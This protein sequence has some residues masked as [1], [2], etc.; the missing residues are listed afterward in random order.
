MVAVAEE[1]E[2]VE[3]INQKYHTQNRCMVFNEVWKLWNGR[4]NYKCKVFSGP[5]TLPM[6][7]F[8]FVCVSEREA[9]TQL[10][11]NHK[12][13]PATRASHQHKTGFLSS[14]YIHTYTYL[15]KLL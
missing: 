2:V 13:R 5:S 9:N 1:V 12:Q 6:D 7:G 15:V 11:R 10:T 3:D 4:E 14:S 8:V